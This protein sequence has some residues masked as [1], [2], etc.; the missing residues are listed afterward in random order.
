MCFT[1]LRIGSGFQYCDKCYSRQVNA[2]SSRY[3]TYSTCIFHGLFPMREPIGQIFLCATYDWII[4]F[5]WK[6]RARLKSGT[7]TIVVG[8]KRYLSRSA[9]T[10]LSWVASFQ[11]ERD[12]FVRCHLRSSSFLYR[13][14]RVSEGS[15][16]ST[17]ATTGPVRIT[18]P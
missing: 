14:S 4:S 2:I 13:A 16:L 11:T 1:A 5:S 8:M 7:L 3:C 9:P 15:S 10:M 6:V 12:R 18:I 17:C